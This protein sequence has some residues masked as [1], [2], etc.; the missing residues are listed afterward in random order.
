M[1]KGTVIIRF[2]TYSEG[3]SLS[4]MDWLFTAVDTLDKYSY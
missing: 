3:G 1:A 4:M 2:Q